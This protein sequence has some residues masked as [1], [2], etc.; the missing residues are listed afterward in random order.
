MSAI[1]ALRTV[2]GKPLVRRAARFRIP[3]RLCSTNNGEVKRA[4][5][6]VGQEGQPTIFDK[7][8]AREIPSDI[9]YETDNVLAFRDVAP[10]A[11]THVLVIP[12]HRGRLTG[13][14]HAEGGDA[15]ILGEL[16]LA[17]SEVARREGLAEDGFR[18]VVNDG[19]NGCQSVH[20]LHLH[21]IGG[22]QL[23]WPPG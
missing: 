18:V 11:P 16:M 3:A 4:A 7:I 20:H 9:V 19:K 13:I 1:G 10:Q 14:R 12:K 17:A 15:P 23:G 22:R 2:V 6:A 8:L 21:V 5:E